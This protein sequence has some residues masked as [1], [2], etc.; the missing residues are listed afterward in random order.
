MVPLSKRRNRERMRLVRS[1]QP[2][3]NL[4]EKTEVHTET[5]ATYVQPSKVSKVSHLPIRPLDDRLSRANSK[6]KKWSHYK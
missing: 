2:A 1:V 3:C 6:S 4:N 5:S